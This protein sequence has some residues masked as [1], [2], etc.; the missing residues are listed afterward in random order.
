[1]ISINTVQC[2]K[3]IFSYDLL[4]N[5]FLAYFI[6]RKYIIEYIIEHANTNNRVCVNLLF[7]LS[8]GTFSQ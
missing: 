7:I 6:V 1:M 8:A 2:Y 5:I 3:C 4:N